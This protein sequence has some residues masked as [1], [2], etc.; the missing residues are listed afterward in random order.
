MLNS[1]LARVKI[2]EATS[3]IWQVVEG[4]DVI[5]LVEANPTSRGDAPV[6]SS[7][8]LLPGCYLSQHRLLKLT[9]VT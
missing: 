2:A 3:W 4:M 8:F 6:H 5:D 9:E 7:S 1:T